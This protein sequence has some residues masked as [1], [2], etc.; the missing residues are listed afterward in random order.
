MSPLNR[1]SVVKSPPMRFCT[2]L[3][4]VN[5]RH[6]SLLPTGSINYCI[7]SIRTNRSLVN[8]S[9]PFS[10]LFRLRKIQFASKR[11]LHSINTMNGSIDDG[12]SLS[13]PTFSSSAIESNSRASMQLGILTKR[14]RY[15]SSWAWLSTLGGG[16]S[17]L[18]EILI[19]HVGIYIC[20]QQDQ[21]SLG[22]FL[23]HP[24]RLKRKRS[25]KIRLVS[26]RK[27]ATR[28]R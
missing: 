10:P 11:T 15:E 4:L 18:G 19:R 16:H 8:F 20:E 7:S 28:M 24:R 21:L 5:S 25:R 22:F 27:S 26:P 14:V 13:A 12:R 3:Y 23:A 6:P 1:S 9:D 17:C 2:L